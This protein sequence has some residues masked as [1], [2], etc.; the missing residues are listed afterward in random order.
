MSQSKQNITKH[1]RSTDIKNPSQQQE[2]QSKTQ[3]KETSQQRQQ[4]QQQQAQQVQPKQK[5]KEETIDKRNN[6]YDKNSEKNNS[7]NNNN[8]LITIRKT[9]SQTVEMDDRHSIP[10]EAPNSTSMETEL[11]DKVEGNNG[12]TTEKLDGDASTSVTISEDDKSMSDDEDHKIATKQREK[13]VTIVNKV[14]FI[15]CNDSR[16]LESVVRDNL[17]QFRLDMRCLGIDI[18]QMFVKMKKKEKKNDMK[19]R[20]KIVTICKKLLYDCAKFGSFM[21]MSYLINL[22]NW[23][24]REIL[25]QLLKNP[26]ICDGNGL[27]IECMPD[28]NGG[29]NAN[30]RYETQ[31]ERKKQCFYFVLKIMSKV[32]NLQQLFKVI[33]HKNRNGLSLLEIL[34]GQ[35]LND[36]ILIKI[37]KVLS[38]MCLV[39]FLC[40]YFV[41]N[42]CKY[43]YS[44]CSFF[45]VCVLL[46]LS[47]YPMVF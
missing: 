44:F 16:I 5:G 42:N 36:E 38:C 37:S 15:Q 4:Q 33:E 11:K 19:I 31:I 47:L 29:V 45:V 21:I 43:N 14:N 18:K 26:I 28:M 32:L 41:V 34:E 2:K 22:L 6:K 24:E 27:L 10:I 35:D 25:Q 8:G 13:V 12:P 39:F 9:P 17:Y 20:D 7:N 30:N 40:V 23:M 46:G 3:E 1:D